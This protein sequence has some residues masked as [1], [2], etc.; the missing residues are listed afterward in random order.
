MHVP[1]IKALTIKR[2]Y[3]REVF[4]T[5]YRMIAMLQTGLDVCTVITHRM[6]SEGFAKGFALMKQ[7]SCGKVVLDWT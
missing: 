2:I 6:P 7:G 1:R 5:R 4:E 3:G